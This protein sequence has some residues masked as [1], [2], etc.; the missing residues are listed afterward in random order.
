V[1]IL[2]A[3]SRHVQVVNGGTL[4]RMMTRARSIG[5]P[6]ARTAT[7]IGAR[8]RAARTAA[9]WTQA[10]LA[11]ES[12]SKAYVSALENGLVQPSMAALGYLAERLGT[13]AAALLAN[14]DGAWTRLEADL[15]LA[16]G[17][18]LEAL[19]A[20]E[21]LLGRAR[22][23]L[24]RAEL[25]RCQAEAL[26]RLDRGSE[27]IGPASEALRIFNDAGREADAA[28]AAYWLAGA[29]YMSDSLAEARTLL[30]NLIDQRGAG[31]AIDPD[32][33][34][35]ALVAAA[36][37]DSR[38]GDQA[39]ALA[40]L[41]E[42]QTVADGFDDLR[43]ASMT[44][45][46]A[47]SYREVGDLEAALRHGQRSLALFRAA[48]AERDAASIGN[49]V[50]LT[51]LALGNLTEAARYAAEA[52][53][54]LE[55]LADTRKLAHVV[56]TQAQIALACGDSAAAIKLATRSLALAESTANTKAVVDALTTRGRAAAAENDQGAAAADF[57]RAAGLAHERG[58][59]ARRAEVLHAWAEM[60]AAAGEH[61]Q[62]Y[63]LMQ[64]AARPA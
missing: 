62:A 15:R 54:T 41:A 52:A 64:S 8:I 22:E 18:W 14:D 29:H 56:D 21:G 46:L 7:G 19:D 16:S 24:A 61:R 3:F 31:H 47:S 13:T 39:G 6:P 30:R 10:Q 53:D 60:L 40:L 55:R 35:R 59:K 27:A 1:S 4:T 51:Y 36:N 32:L 33:H 49:N 12:F 5:R 57:E 42:A 2:A 50:A 48:A 20:Y 11:G 17:N 43:R 9:G 26:C 34:V 23:P 38:S 28:L 63:E 25:L 45:A 58:S 44:Y 37:V